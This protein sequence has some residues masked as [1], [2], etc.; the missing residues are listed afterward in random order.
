MKHLNYFAGS[1]LLALLLMLCSGSFT[2]ASPQALHNSTSVI[3]NSPPE[4]ASFAA[5]PR[6]WDDTVQWVKSLGWDR[7]RLVQIWLFFMLIGLYIILRI[8]PRA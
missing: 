4:A 7:S 1:P 3:T 2:M 8:K 5:A 6:W